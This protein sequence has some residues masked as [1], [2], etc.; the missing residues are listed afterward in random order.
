VNRPGD[1]HLSKNTT[2]IVF[3]DGLGVFHPT[4]PA[5][6]SR[7]H[8]FQLIAMQSRQDGARVQQLV[9]NRVDRM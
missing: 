2:T 7:H 1:G 4:T 9:G 5:T 3:A 6:I 8:L